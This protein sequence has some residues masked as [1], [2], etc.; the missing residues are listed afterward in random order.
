MYGIIDHGFYGEPLA[1]ANANIFTSFTFYIC[2]YKAAGLVT[3]G[4]TYKK[5]T[6]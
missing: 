1:I 6:A 3:E 4:N 2:H 5:P